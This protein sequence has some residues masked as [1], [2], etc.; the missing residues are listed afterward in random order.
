M[1]LLSLV[2][3][4]TAFVAG[5]S[6]PLASQT[7][8]PTRLVQQSDLTRIGSFDLPDVAGGGDR[9][10][11]EY[12]YP[13]AMGYNPATHSLL[14]VGHD[15]DQWVGEVNIPSSLSGATA[16]VRQPCRDI[17]YGKR[18]Q[19][20]GEGNP[21]K[22]GGLLVRGSD[23]IVSGFP[24]YANGTTDG[25]HWSRSTTFSSS[26]VRD[27]VRVGNTSSGTIGGYMAHI[28][29][30]WQAALKGD[31]L[32]GQCCISLINRSSFGPSVSSTYFSDVLTQSR[33][34]ATTLLNY[35]AS[36]PL[37]PYGV[38]APSELWH[39][40]T[41]IR[42]VALPAG[43]A[44]VLFFGRHGTGSWCYGTGTSCGDPLYAEQ[45]EH[46]YPYRAQ[47]WAYNA[48]E[49]AQVASGSRQP[50][51]VRPYAVWELPGFRGAEVAGVAVD[52]D[53][54][55]YVLENGGAGNGRGRVHVYR[56]AGT[57][58]AAG[59]TTPPVVSVTAP[60]GTL[61]GTVTLSA[62]ASDNVG[63]AGVWFTVDGAVVG[64]EDTSAPYQVTWNSGTVAN[65]S[66]TIRALARDAAGNV[67]T[68]APVTVLVSNGTADITAP[69]V[70]LTA[71]AN[72][73]TVKNTVTVSANASDNIGVVSVQFT[74]NGVN[75][76]A[77]DTT[78][79]FAISWNTTG[80]ANGSYTLRAVAR[81]AAGNVTTSAARTV[82]VNNTNGTG[83]TTR[84][85]VSLGAPAN[86]ST[87]RN[88][89]TVAANAS[90]NIGVVSV[91]FTLNGVNLGAPDTTAPFAISWNT[92]SAPN[93]T[94]TLRA[95]ARDAAGNVATSS[96]RTVIVNN[97]T[98]APAPPSAP[99]AQPSAPSLPPPTSSVGNMP[100]PACVTPDPF[101]VLGGGTC[102]NGG[103]LPPGMIPP[104]AAS[105]PASPVL[106]APV[107]PVAPS[108]PAAC[109]TQAPG[110][111]WVCYNGGWLPP[112]MPI[113]ASV[114]APPVFVAPPAITTGCATPRP[115]DGWTCSNGGWLPPNY[116]GASR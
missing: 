42:G 23:L 116:P 25:T 4:A 110:A 33:P 67:S 94:Y 52:R 39:G 63:I 12:Q 44:S 113:P 58:A 47:V 61:S 19:I 101:A 35:P 55:I 16:T 97:T 71:P 21:I 95:V 107:V 41:R 103:W 40:Y 78:A 91:Q 115:G 69:T 75:L 2:V 89:V 92:A 114:V 53:G 7:S 24:Y 36:N 14:I 10:C 86:G 26:T 31:M 81:D 13:G 56:V 32:T 77:P 104:P 11:F 20:P 1:R 17:L 109:S 43:T 45:G 102:H 54:L 99:P 68:S 90:D 62:T 108:A 46:A 59:D 66:H 38:S 18:S 112:N 98:A 87:V 22:I 57:A 51:A 72:G 88:T 82:I 79:P 3:A 105:A 111:G 65:G 80:A 96:A 70:S 100:A 73:A 29:T 15:W 34:G 27:V 8:L 28:P 84:P 5:L 30:E 48:H 49:L 76:G 6:V 83:D 9:A 64:N 50:H 85:T 106:P 60:S 74:L 37:A 93:G